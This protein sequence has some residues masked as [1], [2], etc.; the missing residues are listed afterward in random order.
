MK[1]GIYFNNYLYRFQLKA[2]MTRK[3]QS[4]IEIL[5]AISALTIVLVSLVTAATQSLS[6]S[7]SA[8]TQALATKLAE[9]QMEKI[10]A[11]RDRNGLENLSCVDKC[12][13]NDSLVKLVSQQTVDVLSIWFTVDAAGVTCPAGNRQVTV[14]SQWIDGKGSHQAKLI[15]CF[16]LWQ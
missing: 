11:Y 10:R 8:R 3:G 14:I 16:S 4:L 13:L 7:V 12:Y 15:S 6:G 2:G 5:I 9:D 1:T